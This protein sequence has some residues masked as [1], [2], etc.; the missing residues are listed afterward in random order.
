VCAD[1]YG[2]V[3]RHDQQGVA[4]VSLPGEIDLNNHAAL[5]TVLLGAVHDPAVDRVIVD[6]SATTFIDSSGFRALV[7]AWMA[8]DKADK[9]F[10]A[11]NPPANVRR[12]FEI[13]E[14]RDMLGD[15]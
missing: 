9:R 1:P 14:L 4:R 5:S 15:A 11:V 13:L 7:I 2:I 8:A 3:C 12:M 10:E 6:L